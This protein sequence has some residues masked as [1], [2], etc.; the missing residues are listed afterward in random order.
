MISPHVLH[1]TV[2]ISSFIRAPII[3]YKNAIVR[4]SHGDVR[5]DSNSPVASFLTLS[6]NPNI[7]ETNV[8]LNVCVGCTISNVGKRYYVSQVTLKD[9][10]A[11]AGV[12]Y[13]TVSKVLNNQATVAP[14]TEARVRLA[15]REL[16]YRPNIGARNLR[17]RASNLIGFACYSPPGNGW[18][19]ILDLFLY[20]IANAAEANGYLIT[21]FTGGDKDTYENTNLYADLYA[22]RQVEGFVLADTVQDDPRIAHLIKQ[23]IPF[24]SFGRSN[25]GWD[26]CWVDVDGRA[27]VE[28]VM[29][30]LQERGHERIAL[31][32]WFDRFKT[33]LDREAG[34]LCGLQ[35]AGTPF[36]ADW[37]VRG[38]DS[39][40]T[41]ARGIHSFLSLPAHRRPSAVVC[42][43]DQIAIGAMHAA[44]AAGLQVGRH[45]A[46]TGYDDVPMAKYLHPP[47]TSVGQP[48]DQVGQHVV[49]LLLKQLNNE[50]ILQKGISLKP[51]LVVRESS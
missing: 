23:G 6:L 26:F 11:R 41:G 35:A 2:Y 24:T 25:E 31:I 14:E 47:L 29:T 34:Y 33:G 12:S 32:T 27:G 37:V 3:C 1:F 38:P 39:A 43:S 10:A 20:S 49:E 21:F 22:R 44:M 36:D 4:F 5:R 18:H 15:I 16:N 40:E 9:V 17:T 45:I 42:V 51:R 48:I 28:N 30:H 19:P 13:Q 46:I 8:R 7:V 50:P